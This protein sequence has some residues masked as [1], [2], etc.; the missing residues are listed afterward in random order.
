[1]CFLSL[2]QPTGQQ[3]PSD[4]GERVDREVRQIHRQKPQQRRPI[5]CRARRNIASKQ[6]HLQDHARQRAQKHR[7]AEDG[8]RVARPFA[9]LPHRLPQRLSLC[10]PGA[11]FL[12]APRRV[13]RL[14]PDEI[15]GRHAEVSTDRAE[16]VEVRRGVAVFPLADR[17]ARHLKYF[18]QLLLRQ[19]AGAAQRLQLFS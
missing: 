16:P 12:C 1:M 3:Q 13:L 19:A 10:L 6:E 15:V 18:G 4:N 11:R 7:R 9:V 5:R 14:I 17:L 2:F 8:D